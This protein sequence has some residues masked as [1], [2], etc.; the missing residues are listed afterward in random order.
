MRLMSSQWGGRELRT[1]TVHLPSKGTDNICSNEKEWEETH[2]LSTFINAGIGL[3]TAFCPYGNH[4]KWIWSSSI[5]KLTYIR[6]GSQ[7]CVITTITFPSASSN[8]KVT[9]IDFEPSPCTRL[10]HRS[11][12]KSIADLILGTTIILP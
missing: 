6:P 1:M 5:G 11:L 7:G 10:R 4:V 2:S 8:Y 3:P 9:K 12:Y